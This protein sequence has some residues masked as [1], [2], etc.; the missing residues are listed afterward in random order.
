MIIDIDLCSECGEC[1]KQCKRYA[2]T[3]VKNSGHMFYVTNDNCN[4]CGDCLKN[5][6]QGAIRKR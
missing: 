3:I 5:C 1:I 2:I 6:K 4:N